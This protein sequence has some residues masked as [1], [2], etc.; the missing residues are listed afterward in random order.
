MS[1]ISWLLI[2]KPIFHRKRINVGWASIYCIRMSF[3][4]DRHHSLSLSR[5]SLSLIRTYAAHTDIKQLVA[6]LSLWSLLYGPLFLYNN[7]KICSVVSVTSLVQTQSQRQWSN[8]IV[9]PFLNWSFSTANGQHSTLH[10]S[11]WM[12]CLFFYNSD[13]VLIPKFIF[14]SRLAMWNSFREL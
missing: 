1:V 13:L 4:I 12:L 9:W 3:E 6:S 11:Y 8:V 14:H 2:R 7:K 10:R 5:L